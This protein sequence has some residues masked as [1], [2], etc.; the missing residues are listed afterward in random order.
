MIR[1]ITERKRM[2]ER[3]QKLSQAVEQSP[4]ATVITD[5]DGRF[6]YV[7]PKFLE[8]S[9]YT[10]EELIGKPPA[11]I[12]SGLTPLHIYED[13]WRTILSGMEW[14]GE[15][16]NR[17]KNGELYWE[18]EIIFPVKDEHGEIVNFIAIKEDITERRRAEEALQLKRALLL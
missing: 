10:R 14:R 6:E 2:Q 3:L 8:V 15:I 5:T 18:H 12:K 7:N 1:D 13:L 4:A 16:Q 17:R 9:G 11:I